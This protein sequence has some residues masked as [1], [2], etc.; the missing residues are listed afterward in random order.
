MAHSIATTGT[1]HA[2]VIG[3]FGVGWYGIFDLPY[4]DMNAAAPGGINGGALLN[5][6]AIG[7]RYWL[8]E[9]MGFEGAIG[10]GIQ[11]GGTTNKTG[12]ISTDNN[13]P[14]LFGLALHAALPLAL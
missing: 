10:L 9:T 12:M 6:P 4:G 3:H 11:S 14:S 8:N 2:A 13:E 7:A 1:D 5:A